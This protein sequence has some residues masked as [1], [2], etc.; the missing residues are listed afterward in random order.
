M[1]DRYASDLALVVVAQI[2]QTI[3]YS[4]TLSAPLELLQDILQKFVQEFAQDM[5]GQMEHGPSTT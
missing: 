4:C 3:G 5:H 2:T 1:A